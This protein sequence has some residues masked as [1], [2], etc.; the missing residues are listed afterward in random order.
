MTRLFTLAMI[1]CLAAQAADT[2]GV[3][4]GQTDIGT[5][6]RPGSAE[7]NPETGAYTVRGSG[8]NMWFAED[9]FHF[10][11]TKISTVDVSIGADIQI[12]G[13]DGDNHRKGLL[14]IRQTLDPDSAYVDVAR[15]GDG[16]TS[17]QYRETKGGVTHEIESGVS[18]PARV[19]LEK[20]ADNF[21][22]FIAPERSRLHFAGGSILLHF[23]TPYY[24]GIGACAHDKNALQTVDFRDLSIS[25]SPPRQW[26]SYSTVETVLM[27]T[28]ARVGYVSKKG[29]VTNP[30]WSADGR[31]LSFDVNGGADHVPFVPLATAAKIGD[32]ITPSIVQ[33][34]PVPPDNSFNNTEPILSPDGNYELFLSY[35]K[36][37][38]AV[39]KNEQV[40]LRIMAL[41]DKQIRTLAVFTGGQGSLGPHPWSPDGKRVVFVSYQDLR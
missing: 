25:T 34:V 17:L 4:E 15:H 11:W 37:L 22:M 23:Q 28:D 3:F 29:V 38:S 35:S 8:A 24:I 39:P 30:G 7:F 14:M 36:A 33:T 27:S 26:A 5:V 2:L 10:V 21:Y 40:A 1:A 6:L 12:V 19:R 32:P 18:A 16:L 9:D 13:P 31:E 41:A 20:Q